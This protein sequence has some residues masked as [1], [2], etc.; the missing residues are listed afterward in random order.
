LARS[1]VASGLR[2]RIAGWSM[3]RAASLM[4]RCRR[5]RH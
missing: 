2:Q 5:T 3:R 4:A 1:A